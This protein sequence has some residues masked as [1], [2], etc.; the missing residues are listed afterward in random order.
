VRY[1]GDQQSAAASEARMLFARAWEAGDGTQIFVDGP[2]LM[3]AHVLI[4]DPWHYLKNFA[5]D[6]SRLAVAV[7]ARCPTTWMLAIKIL[8][9]S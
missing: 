5:V 4:Y 6:W 7:G 1:W 9:G 3:V 8:A 2:E